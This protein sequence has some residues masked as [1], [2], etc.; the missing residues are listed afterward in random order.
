MEVRGLGV[1]NIRSMFG[2]NALKIR[3]TLRLI[4]HIEKLTKDNYSSFDRLGNNIRT[5]EI[6]GLGIP[7][8]VLPVAP[9]RNLAILVEAAARNHLL[10][11][12]GYNAAADFIQQQN[13]LIRENEQS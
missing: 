10:Q 11:L 1:V 4:V 5:R 12:N 2:A 13:Q 8:V 7:E 9:G 6:L 3:K